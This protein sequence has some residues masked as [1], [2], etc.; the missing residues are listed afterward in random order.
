MV[1]CLSGEAK[2]NFF[3]YSE[4]AALPADLRGIYISGAYD[5]LISYADTERGAAWSRFYATCVRKT[6]MSNEQ[7]AD[8]VMRFA[9]ARPKFQAHTVQHALVNYLIELCGQPPE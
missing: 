3:T 6:K 7:L 5:S 1:L 9:S 8:N 2:A 4:W